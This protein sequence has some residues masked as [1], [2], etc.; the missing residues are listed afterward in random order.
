M[1]AT[2]VLSYG[3]YKET[4]MSGLDHY[5]WWAFCIMNNTENKIEDLDPDIN[6]LNIQKKDYQ[7]GIGYEFALFNAIN[8]KRAE[9]IAQAR[10]TLWKTVL[11]YIPLW[12]LLVTIILLLFQ[13]I[14]SIIKFDWLFVTVVGIFAS[15]LT[16]FRRAKVITEYDLKVLEYKYKDLVKHM[17]EKG[18]LKT[19]PYVSKYENKRD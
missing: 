6:F 4:C 9:I 11:I 12:I 8:K 2:I 1:T 17:I 14:I 19:E 3:P 10:F 18:W 16:A 5:P 15:F 13:L 7:F